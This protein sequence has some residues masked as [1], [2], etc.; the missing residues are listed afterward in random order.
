MPKPIVIEIKSTDQTENSNTIKL[1][2]E[3]LRGL[4]GIIKRQLELELWKQRALKAEAKL[5]H[6]K[7]LVDK[8]L[9]YES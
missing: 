4:Q 6:V 8:H 2:Q 5:E 1:T 9:G 7:K 3:D